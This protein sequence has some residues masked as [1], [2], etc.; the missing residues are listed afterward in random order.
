MTL[1]SIVS[2]GLHCTAR[3]YNKKKENKY[4]VQLPELIEFIFS[5][6]KHA[7]ELSICLHTSH[8]NKISH[9]QSGKETLNIFAIVMD[10]DKFTLQTIRQ[11]LIDNNLQA[12]AIIQ[13]SQTFS[14]Q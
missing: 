13:V 10:K 5:A 6:D 14:H 12:K 7:E 9:V 4:V 8:Q 2:Q 11:D 3:H 1:F